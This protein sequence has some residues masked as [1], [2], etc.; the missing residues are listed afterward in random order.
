M[1]DNTAPTTTADARIT[2]PRCLA[3]LEELDGRRADALYAVGNP[4]RPEMGE[5]LYFTPTGRIALCIADRI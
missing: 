5:A 3:R 4:A 2:C 1:T